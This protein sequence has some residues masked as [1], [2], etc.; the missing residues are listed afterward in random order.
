VARR[1]RKDEKVNWTCVFS[2]L[3]RAINPRVHDTMNSVI[4]QTHVNRR[5][6]FNSAPTDIKES[7]YRHIVTKIG[8]KNKLKCQVRN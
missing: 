1:T 3:P 8:L 2:I 6:T 7:I 5:K 4:M